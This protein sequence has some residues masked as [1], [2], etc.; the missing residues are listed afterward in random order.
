M[1]KYRL[2]DM[3]WVEAQEAFRRSDTVIFPVGTLH[4]HGPSPIG[5]D[6]ISV[7]AIADRVGK[8]TGLMIL[9]TQVYGEDD[10]MR[11]YP[12]SLTVGQSTM[13]ALCTDI[14]RSLHH[15]GVR[16]VIAL[17]GHGGNREP[18]VRAGRNVRELDM[19]V[20]IVEWWNITKRLQP[21][22][23]TDGTHIVE[24]AVALAAGGTEIADIRTGGYKGEWGTQPPLRKLFG[25][26]IK[27]LG[28]NNFEFGGAPLIIPV[29]AWDIDIASPPEVN[30]SDL[31]A[32]RRRGEQIIDRAVEYV[33]AFANEIQK[34]DVAKALKQ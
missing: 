31:E 4:G 17:N 29:D 23:C 28:F 24:L 3:S 5:I 33:I 11:D 12:G 8:Q 19:L 30:K 10:K 21:E 18:L 13:E 27:P 2:Q 22:L 32:L 14:F 16:K 1:R 9:P 15:N 34:L 25:E 6:A 26:A 20:P 7:D